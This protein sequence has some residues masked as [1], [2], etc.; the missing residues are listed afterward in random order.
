MP[1]APGRGPVPQ[2]GG[3]G[4][5]HAAGF[6]REPVPQGL[7]MGARQDEQLRRRLPRRRFRAGDPSL[8]VV[9]QAAP[10]PPI[11]GMGACPSGAMAGQPLTVLGREKLLDF[12]H[13]SDAD[14]AV[15]KSGMFGRVSHPT[16][17]TP[18]RPEDIRPH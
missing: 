9:V 3:T 13:I 10:M 2:G 5:S 11:S 15:G 12:T 16:L 14:G 8:K 4:S 17:K 1:P 6:G 18:T 7:G